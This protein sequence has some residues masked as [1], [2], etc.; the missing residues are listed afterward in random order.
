M[1]LSALETILGI[2]GGVLLLL[3]IFSLLSLAQRG[4]A[5]LDQ[6]GIGEAEGWPKTGPIE[7]GECP[8]KRA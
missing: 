5:H 2:F 6:L 4:D 1:S 3:V 7:V 8:E